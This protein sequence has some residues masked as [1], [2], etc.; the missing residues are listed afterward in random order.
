MPA[1]PFDEIKIKRQK[2][3]QTRQK[4]EVRKKATLRK[5]FDAHSK[6][7]LGVLTQLQK[8]LYPKK[9]AKYFSKD[10]Y[11]AIVNNT[12]VTYERDTFVKIKLGLGEDTE[13]Y[14]FICEIYGSVTIE[15]RWY[16][17]D[18]VAGGNV[19]EV[20]NSSSCGLSSESLTHCLFELHKAD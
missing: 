4:E 14:Y 12:K 13:E 19:W 20:T 11:W 9:K 5:A 15:G 18:Y 16:G 1:N 7:V 17:D 8:A 2:K 10:Y 6:M 3:E